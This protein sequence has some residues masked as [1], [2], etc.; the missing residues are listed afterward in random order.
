MNELIRTPRRTWTLSL[1]S[2]ALGAVVASSLSLGV[3]AI[4]VSALTISAVSS[5]A[6]GTAMLLAPMSQARAD[7]AA[8]D[9]LIRELSNKVLEQIKNDKEIQAGNAKRISDFIDTTI[10]PSVNFERMTS[11][12]VG[13]GW[14][15][16]SADQQKRLITEFRTLLIRTYSGAIT[17]FKDQSIK[18]KPL[19][20][21][22]ADTEVIVRTEIT[23]KRG[24]AIPLDYRME[25]SDTGWKIYDVNVGSLWL[26]ESYRNQFSSEL[27]ARGIDGLIA[28]LVSKNK[29]FET[30]E[31]K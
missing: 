11:L 1:R 8:P 18:V 17:Q 7:V 22:A 6:L 13:R 23:P 26:V 19:R 12:S 14:R 16:A 10:M 28:L 21:A 30:A 24:E 4:G 2:S 27:N 31:K 3:G 9:E 25:K 5:A 15:Q 29:Q 20:A